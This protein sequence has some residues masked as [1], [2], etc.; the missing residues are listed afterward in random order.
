[1]KK[2]ELKNLIENTI[3]KVL[4]E[5]SEYGDLSNFDRRVNKEYLHKILKDLKTKLSSEGWKVIV[6]FVK[7]AQGINRYGKI[8]SNIV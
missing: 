2:T 3:K 4:S 6:K 7:G 8:Y 5:E 1:M